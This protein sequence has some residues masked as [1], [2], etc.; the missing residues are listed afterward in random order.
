[1]K[2]RNANK[3]VGKLLM[4][5]LE[6]YGTKNNVSKICFATNKK[7]SAVKFYKDLG[8]IRSSNVIYMEK[9]L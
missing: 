6:E 1:M 8:Y 7:S 9:K 4:S 3:G 5:R 2:I